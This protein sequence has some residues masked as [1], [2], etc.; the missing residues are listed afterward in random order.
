VSGDSERGMQ[1]RGAMEVL[2]AARAKGDVMITSMGSAREWIAMCHASN[3]PLDPLDFIFVPSSMGQAP[4]LALG[5]ALAQPGRR[6]FACNGDGSTLMN[7]GALATI[8]AECPT[9][10]VLIILDNGVYEVTGA[11][12]TPGSALGRPDQRGVDFAEIARACGWQSVYRYNDLDDWRDGAND[13]INSPGPVFIVLE[14]APVPGAVG[15]KSPGPTVGRAQKFRE[16]LS[17][18]KY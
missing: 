11:Q 1:L 9:N 14:V 16:A 12:P 5:I 18:A 8:S 6:V 2:R 4:S 15:P 7:L 3:E 10:L 17:S 13:A